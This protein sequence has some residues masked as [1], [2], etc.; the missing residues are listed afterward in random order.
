MRISLTALVLTAAANPSFVQTQRTTP[1]STKSVSHLRAVQSLRGRYRPLLV[2]SPIPSD[3]FCQQVK[4]LASHAAELHDRDVAIYYQLANDAAGNPAC[5]LPA[6]D[7]NTYSEPRLHERNGDNHLFLRYH[8]A[9]T[10][11][12]VLLLGKDGGEKLRSTKPISFET[13]RDTIDTMPM[14]KQEA[15]QRAHP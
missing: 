13:L 9:P 4:E 2:F 12:T 14:R 3:A 1:E 8:V 6:S 7:I 10:D 15:K 5:A 11:F